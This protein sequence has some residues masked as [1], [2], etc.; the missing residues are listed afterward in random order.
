[1]TCI[2][3]QVFD[4]GAGEL[5]GWRVH[6]SRT[7]HNMDAATLEAADE[8]ADGYEAA[9]EAAAELRAAGHRAD[10]R[11]EPIDVCP[12]CRD[13]QA[14]ADQAEAAAFLADV[15]D[16]AE[17]EARA[18]ARG[19]A[20]FLADTGDQP[21]RAQAPARCSALFLGASAR[22][23]RRYLPSSSPIQPPPPASS[24]AS[25]GTDVPHQGAELAELGQ[26]APM[27]DD[28]NTQAEW[29]RMADQALDL[30]ARNLER[31]G[32]LAD[33]ELEDLRRQLLA[34]VNNRRTVSRVLVHELGGG[35]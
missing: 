1:M 32:E 2:R 4:G 31:C 28:R 25:S 9:D 11:Q 27:I 6:W 33:P 18:R 19:G 10:V 29:L 17:A 16:Q 15:G 30:A 3:L 23:P 34:D 13:A 24:T 14:S 5:D 20:L 7:F 35:S 26:G 12:T 21:V 8:L 22:V